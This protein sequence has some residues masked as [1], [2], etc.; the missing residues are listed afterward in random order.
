MDT[1]SQRPVSLSA[2]SF[3]MLICSAAWFIGVYEWYVTSGSTDDTWS[4]IPLFWMLILTVT[5]VLCVIVSVALMIARKRSQ[6]SWLER[7]ALC[8][9]FIPVVFIVLLACVVLPRMIFG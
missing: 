8:A 6:F 5:P 9:A 7:C 4:S 2:L 3:V 1:L